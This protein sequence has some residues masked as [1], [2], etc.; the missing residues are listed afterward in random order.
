M[1]AIPPDDPRPGAGDAPSRTGR[2]RGP[3]PVATA[4]TVAVLV[5]V[6]VAVLI[7]LL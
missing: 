7:V 2:P 3:V 4:L 5:A 1:A 6:I